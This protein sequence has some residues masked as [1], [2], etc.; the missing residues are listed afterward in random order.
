MIVPCLIIFFALSAIG[1]SYSTR[2][3]VPRCCNDLR[4]DQYPTPF[5]RLYCPLDLCPKRWCTVD[6]HC[7][8]NEFCDYT[9][10]DNKWLGA[11]MPKVQQA[12]CLPGKQCGN[13][14]CKGDEVC[15]SNGYGV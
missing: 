13:T 2:R 6:A 12:H 7:K 15:T 9:Q 3:P 8:W 1:N 14:C 11:C 5:Q 10:A 4:P